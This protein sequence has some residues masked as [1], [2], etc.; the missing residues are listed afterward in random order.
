MSFVYNVVIISIA[1]GLLYGIT[2][3]P[4]PTSPLAGLDCVISDSKVFGNSPVIR[5]V[6]L[7]PFKNR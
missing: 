1:N 6:S 3:S 2:Y 7:V 5:K 4:M